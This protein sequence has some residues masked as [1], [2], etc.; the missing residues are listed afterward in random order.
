MQ[1]CACSKHWLEFSERIVGLFVHAKKLFDRPS[2]GSKK[3]LWPV[4]I[5]GGIS[6]A[7]YVSIHTLSPAALRNMFV[8]H[9]TL[10]NIILW[11]PSSH[12]STVSIMLGLDSVAV[13][14]IISA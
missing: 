2:T 7:Q 5:V 4:Q 8:V 12:L 9:S 13:C 6:C 10:L 1:D 14:N 11:P 3:N